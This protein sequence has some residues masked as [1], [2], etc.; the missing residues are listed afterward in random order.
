MMGAE[1]KCDQERIDSEWTDSVEF[2]KSMGL[3]QSQF[4]VSREEVLAQARAPL[5]ADSDFLSKT[6]SKKPNNIRVAG[7]GL[8]ASTVTSSSLI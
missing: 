2:L 7:Q 1:L 5:V 3:P 4:G 6:P 8:A